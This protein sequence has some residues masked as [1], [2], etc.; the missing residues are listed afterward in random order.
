[1]SKV[2]FVEMRAADVGGLT[3]GKVYDVH[4]V[5]DDSVGRIVIITDDDGEVSALLEGEW[6][7]VNE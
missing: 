1:M 3:V 2:R 4:P 6:E 5:N 7:Y